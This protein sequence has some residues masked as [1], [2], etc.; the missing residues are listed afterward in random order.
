MPF[1]WHRVASVPL[2]DGRFEAIVCICAG[3]RG[4]DPGV[5]L[6]MHPSPGNMTP[7]EARMLA[8]ALIA[9]SREAEES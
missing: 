8:A 5:Q 4:S 7:P 6:N 2:D 1:G 3:A 9:A